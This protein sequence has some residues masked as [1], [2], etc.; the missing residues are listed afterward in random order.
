VAAVDEVGC[1]YEII[2]IDDASTDGSP[3]V[4][5]AYQASTRTCRSGFS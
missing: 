3:E 1:S 2:V 4:V 5:R